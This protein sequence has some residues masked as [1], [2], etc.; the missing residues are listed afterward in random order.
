MIDWPLLAMIMS[1]E[2]S[3]AWYTT[4]DVMLSPGFTV[5][6]SSDVCHDPS[7]QSK[8]PLKIEKTEPW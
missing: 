1:Y 8:T 7:F 2:L 5:Y 6:V 4:L 3:E